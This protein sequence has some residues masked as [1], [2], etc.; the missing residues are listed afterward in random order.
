MTLDNSRMESIYRNR[1]TIAATDS[2]TDKVGFSLSKSFNRS[3]FRDI[4]NVSP[5]VGSLDVRDY[6]VKK[7]ILKIGSNNYV[8]TYSIF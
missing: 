4:D 3:S 7:P 5:K 2:V 8:D 1:S 6:A